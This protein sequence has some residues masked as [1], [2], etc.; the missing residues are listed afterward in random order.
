MEHFDNVRLVPKANIYDGGKCVSHTFYSEDWKKKTAG[1][2]FPATH[3][4]NTEEPERMDVIEGQCRV[5]L[6]G[7]TDWKEYQKG[8]FFDVPGHSSFDIEI[9]ETMHYICHFG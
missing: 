8:E 9:I 6:A 5:R 1:V 4:F 7:E 3:H 2:M